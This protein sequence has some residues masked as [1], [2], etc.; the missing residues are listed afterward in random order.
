MTFVLIIDDDDD[1]RGVLRLMLESE[2]FEVAE[3]RDGAEGIQA[4]RQQ[5]ADLVFCDLF[6]PGKDG[7]EVIQELRR[8]F[9]GVKVIAMSGG[10]YSG[11]MALLDVARQLGAV[12]ALSKPFSVTDAVAAA[13]RALE[14]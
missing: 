3:S 6:M 5:A 9:P 8:D 2:G 12:E 7:L 11:T 1:V 4:L 14:P 13:R 10:G